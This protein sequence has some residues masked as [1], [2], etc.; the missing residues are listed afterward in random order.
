M[1]M[2]TE[3]RHA[4]SKGPRGSA[5]AKAREAANARGNAHETRETQDF[6]RTGNNR[7]MS[8]L[9]LVTVVSRPRCEKIRHVAYKMEDTHCLVPM[10]T[11]VQILYPR[12]RE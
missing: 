7:K 4:A 10:H 5:K 2:N 9:S 3:L 1:F 8:P 6:D 12:Q 11:V